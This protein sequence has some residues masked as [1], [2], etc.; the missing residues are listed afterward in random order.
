MHKIIGVTLLIASQI[1]GMGSH[2][3][4][5]KTIT[6]P[7]VETTPVKKYVP[8]KPTLK[9]TTK[10]SKNTPAKS[11]SKTATATPIVATTTPKIPVST[12]AVI[13]PPVASESILKATTT[14]QAVLPPADF[15][16]INT[17]ARSATVNILCTVKGSELSPISGT[18][19]IISSQGVIL[20]NAH[21]AQYFLLNNFRIKNFITCVAR[22]GSPAYP[23]YN[24][25]LMYIS[26]KWVEANKTVLK[27]TNP[28]G[29]GEND[30]ALLRITGKIEGGI[31]PS[32]FN[33]ITPNANETILIG[34]PVVLVS[35]PA[36]FLGGLSILQNLNITSAETTVQDYY[37][38]KENTIDLISV[39]GTVVSQKGASGGGVIDG[40][41]N[42]I[43][44]ITTSSEAN[45]TNARDLRAITIGYINR[46]IQTETG[47]SLEQILS[48]NSADFATKF[49][50]ETAPHL[51]TLITDELLK[52]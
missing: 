16:A 9:P 27:D 40:K 36:G 20:T 43:G 28:Q 38:Y 25:E 42:I 17:F 1:W 32:S 19:V 6:T 37:T 47:W 50:T 41:S 21:V 24:L 52:P 44:I 34:D 26:P 12:E 11:L 4:V 2:K 5:Q 30:F 33:H 39:P 45:S 22:T 14:V 35:Y 48:Q 46:A 49:Q 3:T 23:V 15:T 29:T 51:T 31:L 7:V 13:I 18:G 10:V 8:S